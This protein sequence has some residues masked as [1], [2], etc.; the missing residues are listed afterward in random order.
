MDNSTVI[1]N[2]LSPAPIRGIPLAKSIGGYLVRD[3]AVVGGLVERK[4]YILFSISRE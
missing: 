4:R 1:I 3:A 2:E